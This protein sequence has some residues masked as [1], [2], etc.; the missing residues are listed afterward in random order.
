MALAEGMATG[1]ERDGLFVVHGHTGERFADV[2]GGGERVGIAVRAFR[3]DVDEAHLHG[4]EMAGELTVAAVALVA[5]EPGLFGT[6]VDVLLGLPYVDPA[7][8]EAERLEAHGLERAGA[9]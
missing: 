8:G 1:D 6:P 4:A 5:T 7:T 9:G 2:A 3:V